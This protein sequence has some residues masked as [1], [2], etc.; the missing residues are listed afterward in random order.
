MKWH[1]RLDLATGKFSCLLTL[2]LIAA[3]VTPL[4]TPDPAD[5][6]HGLLHSSKASHAAAATL[7][8]VPLPALFVPGKLSGIAVFR[9]AL[10]NFLEL[11][12]IA[13]C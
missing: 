9:P 11:F 13:R 6:I 12:C 5:D 1:M 10:L 3:V 2:L 7:A 8:L 4:I